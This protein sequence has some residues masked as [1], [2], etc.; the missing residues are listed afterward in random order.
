MITISFND[1]EEFLGELEKDVKNN[2]VHRNIL[3]LT[4]RFTASERVGF[5]LQFLTI[6]SSYLCEESQQIVTLE[7]YIGQIWQGQDNKETIEKSDEIMSLIESK[8][9]ELN[10]EIRAG[11]FKVENKK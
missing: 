7:K 5:A 8:A 10:L 6:I 1:T 2:L 3:R 9:K 11:T 4:R